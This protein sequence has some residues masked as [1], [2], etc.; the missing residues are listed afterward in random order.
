MAGKVCMEGYN[1]KNG[2]TGGVGLDGYKGRKG[3]TGKG[4]TIRVQG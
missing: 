4:R 3:R 1:D 2:R